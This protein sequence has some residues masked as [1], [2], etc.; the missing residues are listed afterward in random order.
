MNNKINLP[1]KDEQKTG[2]TLSSSIINHLTDFKRVFGKKVVFHEREAGELKPIFS[3]SHSP[4]QLQIEPFDVVKVECN[5]VGIDSS[6]IS[7]GETEEGCLYSV[8]SGVFIYS[9]SRPKTYYSFGPYVV[10]VDDDVV[11]KIYCGTPVKEKVVRLVALDAEYA[12]KLIRFIFEREILKQ[13]C[14]ILRDSIILVDGSLKSTSLELDGI[15]LKKILDVSLENGNAVV[16]LSKSS[17]LKVIK[18]IANY[19]ELLNYAPVKV[20]VHHILEDVVEGLEGHVFIVKF[21]RHG[22]AFRVDVPFDLIFEVDT[23]LGKILW[24]DSFRYGYPESLIMAHNL[25]VFDRVEEVSVKSAIAKSLNIVQ[26]PAHNLR[27]MLLN[28]L[29][30]EG[31]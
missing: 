2:L 24:N 4:L 31:G 30:F 21:K 13:I 12:K 17:R 5:V 6:C 20:D 28:G 15:S 22:Y 8:K 27:K 25:S 7:I 3:I 16:G 14:S 9:C 19:I 18:N 26:V 11:R 10:Y 29:K 1:V 23:I